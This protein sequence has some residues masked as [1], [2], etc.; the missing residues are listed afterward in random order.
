MHTNY[1]RKKIRSRNKKGYWR[2]YSLAAFRTEKNREFR[3]LERDQMAHGRFDD[4]PKIRYSHLYDW[5]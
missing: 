4:L 3:A 2:P 5:W 1:R